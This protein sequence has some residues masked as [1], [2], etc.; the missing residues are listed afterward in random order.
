MPDA[1][2][3]SVVMTV[4][5]TER[6]VGEAV[7]SVLGQTFGDFEFVIVDDGSTD[8]S[9]TILK[10]FAARDP[11]IRLVSRPNTGIV[12]AA[13]E[14]IGLARGRYLARMDSDDVCLP[15]RFETQVNYLEQHPECVLVGSRV[16]VV[17]P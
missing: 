16:T 13:N 3:V 14:G 5:N 10:D 6:Y 9:T 11:R 1:P 17:D 8:R 12:A 4:Y 7:G 15:R 2:T